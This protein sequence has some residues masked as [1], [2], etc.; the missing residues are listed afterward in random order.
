MRSM[1]YLFIVVALAGRSALYLFFAKKNAR[2]KDDTWMAVVF[3]AL[4][5]SYGFYAFEGA[6]DGSATVQSVLDG[7]VAVV[8]VITTTQAVLKLLKRVRG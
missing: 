4:A 1:L 2:R 3:A 5:I 8:L 7:G 6:I